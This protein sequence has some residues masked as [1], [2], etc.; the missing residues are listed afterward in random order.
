MRNIDYSDC[1][2]GC[3]LRSAR[4]EDAAA[5]Y[6]QNFAPLDPEVA[7]LTGCKSV[8]SRQE[9]TDFFLSS[10]KADG[11]FTRMCPSSSNQKLRLGWSGGSGA[12][13]R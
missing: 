11:F 8:F 5:Y 3:T 13:F 6:E 12:G 1:F 7:R 4:P 10:Q 2:N 9:V